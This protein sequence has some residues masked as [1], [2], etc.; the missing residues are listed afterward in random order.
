MNNL[1]PTKQVFNTTEM[2]EYAG[3]SRAGLHRARTAPDSDFP[4]PFALSVAPHR[5]LWRRSDI[6]AWVERHSLPIMR[7][8]PVQLRGSQRTAAPIK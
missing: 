4:Q 2:L 3:L 1:S 5:N 7:R 8:E 6:D